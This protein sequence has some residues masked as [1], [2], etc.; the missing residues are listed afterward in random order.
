MILK[1]FTVACDSLV[2]VQHANEDELTPEF[3]RLVKEL[4][5]QPIED[6]FIIDSVIANQALGFVHYFNT[7]KL[8]L[9]TYSIDPLENFDNI[10]ERICKDQSTKLQVAGPFAAIEQK[11]INLMRKIIMMDQS[12]LPTAKISN[13]N[14][15]SSLIEEVMEILQQHRL[16]TVSIEQANNHLN[17]RVFYKIKHTILSQS[18]ELGELI[19]NLGLPIQGVLD[20][21]LLTEQRE[22]GITTTHN[23]KRDR[24]SF[25]DPTKAL[26]Q[27][28]FNKNNGAPFLK[29]L[30]SNNNSLL[31]VAANKTSS[32][33]TKSKLIVS[34]NTNKTNENSSSTKHSTPSIVD[35]TILMDSQEEPPIEQ[36]IQ[37]QNK[38]QPAQ[39]TKKVRLTTDDEGFASENNKQ[40]HQKLYTS[41]SRETS[42]SE[43]ESES[44][45]SKASTMTKSQ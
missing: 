10:F 40:P 25:S 24:D 34:K 33:T 44:A 8:L 6:H 17:T 19:G 29:P 11:K 16:G 41:S 13:G 30:E 12:R 28:N 23:K 4:T 36:E 21:M 39:I 26:P 18:I 5:N 43:S 20:H 9:A 32:S 3:E 31:G 15:A 27:V 2:G 37:N 42:S 38:K 14:I 45:K 7:N 35:A 1:A 22:A